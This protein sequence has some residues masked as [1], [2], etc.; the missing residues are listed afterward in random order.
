V[1]HLVEKYSKS[2]FLKVDNDGNALP[3]GVEGVESFVKGELRSHDS[4]ILDRVDF[5]GANVLEFG[6]GRGESTKYVWG[7][8]PKAYVGVDF[9]EAACEIARDFLRKF[10][11]T[12]PELVCA[13]AYEFSKD[14]ASGRLKIFDGEI[15]VIVMLDFVEH[16]PRTEL[17]LMLQTLRPLLSKRAVIVV[18]TPDFAFDNDVIT[19]GL[20]E[21]GKDSSDF[22]P[23][24][25]GMHCNRYTLASL[26]TYFESLNFQSISE[27]HYFAPICQEFNEWRGEQSYRLQWEAA[28]ANG[29]RI[30]GPWVKE[31]FEI[32]YPV[33]NPAYR[34]VFESGTLQGITIHLA[35]SY[36]QYYG[37]GNY[38]NFLIQYIKK[39][40]LEGKTVFDLGAYVGANSM[41]FARL[42]GPKGKVCAFEP[43]PINSSRLK[44]NLSENPELDDRILTFDF[45]LSDTE[46][47]LKFNVHRNVDDGLSSASYFAGA[48]TTL[49][50]AELTSLGFTAINAKVKTVDA[51][52]R[53]SGNI[54]F[55]MKIDIEGSEHLAL[56]GAIDTLR[57]HRPVIVMELHSIFCTLACIDFLKPLGYDFELLYVEPDGRCFVGA[58][59]VDRLKEPQAISEL[60][61]DNRYKAF[62]IST[63]KEAAHRSTRSITALENSITTQMTKVTTVIEQLTKVQSHLSD[64]NFRLGRLDGELNET[65]Q[66]L[67]SCKETNALDATTISTFREQVAQ[68]K[69]E[70]I[71]QNA[72]LEKSRSAF[73]DVELRSMEIT[74]T[75]GVVEKQ[76]LK[77]QLFLPIRLMRFLLKR[78]RAVF[79]AQ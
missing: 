68:L 56:K 51:F 61:Q 41:Q 18:N 49:Q 43:N 35:P 60:E 29:I 19:E 78:V 64:A 26:S 33:H 12:G 48:H 17:T 22:I 45:G 46:E 32:T 4:E 25:Q 57:S 39:F 55:C 65:T 74:K 16:I 79:G 63:L 6:F 30:L 69:S 3:Y 28:R 62:E 54:P 13:D 14:L 53:E 66:K 47:V 15:D 27:G 50:E 72:M 75:L 38:D 73:L 59:C 2:Y 9:S 67:Q 10:N 40:D 37:D 1:G 44:L 52:V 36:L 11:V 70:L 34:H 20:I 7:K 31:A 58:L 23:E 76:L 24:T 71:D 5:S 21:A 42:V 77:Y 8:S